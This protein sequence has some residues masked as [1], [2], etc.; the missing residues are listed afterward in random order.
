MSV[1]I[2]QDAAALGTVHA[3]DFCDALDRTSFAT[4]RHLESS[5]SGTLIQFMTDGR[6]RFVA[7]NGA[8]LAQTSISALK[9]PEATA[10]ATVPASFSAQIAAAVG[11]QESLTLGLIRGGDLPR[12]VIRFDSGRTLLQTLW[13]DDAHLAAYK[14]M[15]AG[16]TSTSAAIPVDGF[17][18][19]AKGLPRKD[20]LTLAIVPGK[21]I[22]RTSKGM[23]GAPV[24]A[25]VWGPPEQVVLTNE[26]F[27]AGWHFARGDYSE[28]LL[29][30]RQD[31]KVAKLY[32]ADTHDP[33]QPQFG[34]SEFLIRTGTYPDAVPDIVPGS[35]S[36]AAP[37]PAV[38]ADARRRG[39]A[40]PE[41]VESILAELD[42]I[43]GQVELKEQVRRLLGQVRVNK[44]RKE[45]GL[46]TSQMASHMIF[47]GP[48]GTGKTTVAR[49]LARLL[50]ALEV[51]P[52]DEVVEVDKSG[53]VAAHVGG[54]EEK[55][56]KAIEQA[57]GGVLFID[58]AYQL[59]GDQFGEIAID[60]LV[61]ALED[62]RGDFVAIAAGYAEEMKAFVDSNPGIQ[63]RFLRTITFAPYS[64]DELVEIGVNMAEAGDNKLDDGALATLRIRL[65]DEQR[66][67]GFE[68]KRWGNARA[69]RNVIESATAAR[70]LRIADAEQFEDESLITITE[71]DMIGACDG[72]RI[73][74]S[75]GVGES[76][77]DVLAELD[78]QVGQPQLK[79]QVR[80]MVAGARAA[81]ILAAQG[82]ASTPDIPPMIFMGPPGTG[83]T[84]VARLIARLYRALG[85]L[86]GG[87]VI[88]VDRSGLVASH[89]GGTAEK[90]TKAIDDAMGGVLFIDEAYTLVSGGDSFGKE[91][92]ETVLKRL[93]DDAGKFLTIAAGYPDQ[94]MA[95]LAA[96][97]GLP[98]RFSARI[99]FAAYTATELAQIA[100]IMV[101]GRGQRFSDDARVLLKSRLDAAER[102]GLFGTKDWG[103]AGS[104][105][106]IIAQA[107]TLRNARLFA[108]PDATPPTTEDLTTLAAE[109][110]ALACDRTLGVGAGP[111]ESVEDILAELDRQVGQDQLKVQVQAL[112]AEVRVRKQRVD[113]G[114]EAGSPDLPHLLFKGPPGTGK[115]TIARLLARLYKALGL[116]PSGRVIEVDRGGLVASHVGGTAEKTAKAVEDAMGGVLFIDEAYTLVSG[117]DSF[118]REA[119][120]TLLKRMSDDAGKFLTIAAGYSDQMDTFLAANDGLGRRFAT[121]IEFAPYSADELARI[122]EVM[123]TNR[124]EKLS[125]D[126][127]TTLRQ[128]LETAER[129]G[130]FAAK[131]WG[132][133]GSVANI[134][135]KAAQA[136]NLRLTGSAS[137]EELVTINAEDIEPACDSV[138]GGAGASV[139]TVES[140]LAELDSQIGQPSVKRQIA[141]LMAGVRAQQARRSQGIESSGTLI[142]HLVFTGP[143]GTGKTT[144]ARLLARLYRA[145]GVLPQGQVIE[146]DRAG[147]VAGY[148]GQTATKT[149]EQ[150]EKA[151]G[152][153]LFIDEAYTLVGDA[154]G[155]EAID[156][157]LAR[158]ENDRGKFMVISAGYPEQMQDF[159]RSNPG[160]PSRFAQP[161]EFHPYTA[162]E[163]AQIAVSMA[164]TKGD[165]FTDEA[166]DLLRDRLTATE[167]SGAFTAREWGNARTIRN[168]VDKAGKLRNSRIY[169]DPASD[170]GA[171]DLVILT[172]ADVA[173]ASESIGLV[174]VERPQ[175][176]SATSADAGA[177]LSV[178]EAI[179][180]LVGGVARRLGPGAVPGVAV[181]AGPELAALGVV[182]V[183]WQRAQSGGGGG[184]GLQMRLTA[185]SRQ[186]MYYFAGGSNGRL[187]AQFHDGGDAVPRGQERDLSGAISPRTLTDWQHRSDAVNELATAILAAITSCRGERR[188]A[189][190]GGSAPSIG[191]VAEAIAELVGGVARRLGPGAVPGV[192]VP[193]G[194]ELAA[195]GVVEVYWQRAQSGGGGGMGL[196]MR[197]TAGSRQ[198]MYYFA[199]GSNGRLPAQFH[200]GGDAVPR[201]Q[202]RDLSGAISP[203]TLTD[204]QH[205]SDAVN[206]LATAIL[207]AI[208]SCRSN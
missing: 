172:A 208:T 63:S 35:D 89:V 15:T 88:E 129:S 44:D 112:L 9:P 189:P 2:W 170:P 124:G 65:G 114:L 78:K 135:S 38:E 76:V 196:Q 45:R 204:W 7:S 169:A 80:E 193:A 146:V 28:V 98:R 152:G 90:T 132:N 91:A 17:R 119:I 177:S 122:A 167:V 29:E 137:A 96:N 145:L 53:L 130:N 149:E 117:D 57:I 136:R 150:I 72:F 58:E 161:I 26:P 103:N 86:S 201:G 203:R 118:G 31:G 8:L 181:P 23:H 25:S 147:L 192:A 30:V 104:V 39:S 22:L 32:G 153:V 106:N 41:S 116:L 34:D 148:V 66:R 70:D 102:D 141:S 165:R 206:E 197:L 11:E 82:L 107:S 99:E 113:M 12:L 151:Q 71:I 10:I 54:T 42:S 18:T 168:L 173:A 52:S 202:E 16:E 83:K 174:S 46:K 3:G 21:V 4:A 77:D 108:D 60:V 110:V 33:A 64:T 140:V 100:E 5:L 48:P 194:P 87:Q 73:G 94:M 68:D 188:S 27:A 95:F 50:H 176:A 160:L 199:G 74:R 37:G 207:A 6:V 47:S 185:G 109:D 93:T 200:D 198:R 69:V 144:I 13:P 24:M 163:L 43:T 128:R 19:Q 97:P 142:E 79:Q 14:D 164:T 205:R 133:A 125:G 171:Q 154:F 190:V 92:L 84:T 162:D 183:Y 127:R 138:L 62:R 59:A 131:D 126:A 180:E 159:L 139:D 158:M 51:L 85:L 20:L 105:G 123:T 184:M 186:R 155:R 120:N 81:Q 36:A 75:V 175:S 143:P 121:T 166:R 67:G 195:L 56:T 101:E 55:T 134:L 61:K 49:L 191:S 179:A 178:A 115:T 157:L 187:P 111:R 40:S 156:T 1:D 182:E